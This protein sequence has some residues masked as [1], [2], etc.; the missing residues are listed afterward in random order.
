MQASSDS[1]RKSEHKCF[2]LKA[3]VATRAISTVANNVTG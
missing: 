2:L 3:D 1:Y